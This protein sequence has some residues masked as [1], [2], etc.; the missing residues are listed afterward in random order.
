MKAYIQPALDAESM[1]SLEGY[2][3]YTERIFPAAAVELKLKEDWDY[4]DLYI[5]ILESIAKKMKI[6]RF[7]VYTVDELVRLIQTKLA[8]NS[9]SLEEMGI[10]PGLVDA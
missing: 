3:N 10:L 6:N 9:H 5:A 2:R 1:E 7:E 4:K 8:K